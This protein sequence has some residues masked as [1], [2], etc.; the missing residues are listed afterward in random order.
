MRTI[1]HHGGIDVDTDTVMH[2]GG[3][4][5]EEKTRILGNIGQQWMKRVVMTNSAVTA[6][7]DFTPRWFHSMYA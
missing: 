3:K 4:D 5:E 1:C 7:V 6:G 2:Y